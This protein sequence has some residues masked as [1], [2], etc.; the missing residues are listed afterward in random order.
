F[1]PDG[2][3]LVFSEVFASRLV[4]FDI[5]PDGS[6]INERVFAMLDGSADGIW[7]DAEGAV[8]SATTNMTSRNTRWERV[9]ATGKVLDSIPVPDGFHAIACALGGKDGRDLFLVANKTDTPD[10]VWN[11]RARSRVF[12]TRANVPTAPTL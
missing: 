6:L 8:W 11:G 3:G 1:T 4:R 12:R 10:D 2:R 5:A 9:D 7:M